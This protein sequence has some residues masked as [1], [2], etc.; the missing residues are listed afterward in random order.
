MIWLFYVYTDFLICFQTIID[1]VDKAPISFITWE[2]DPTTGKLLHFGFFYRKI[3]RRI[4]KILYS[5]H[6]NRQFCGDVIGQMMVCQNLDVFHPYGGVKRPS[7]FAEGKKTDIRHFRWLLALVVKKFFQNDYEESCSPFFKLIFSE[8]FLHRD[9]L[10][11]NFMFQY[12]HPVLY[13]NKQKFKFIHALKNFA[14]H[15]RGMFY[16]ENGGLQNIAYG[17]QMWWTRIAEDK[18]ETKETMLG[19]VYYYEETQAYENRPNTLLTYIRNLQ[20]HFMKGIK[21]KNERIRSQNEQNREENI[22]RKAVNDELQYKKRGH[23]YEF[24]HFLFRYLS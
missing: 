15:N 3:F 1:F 4:G 23:G 20:E 16:K 2:F 13:G 14:D 21:T 10:R 5:Y 8:V 17:F 18:E 22:R 9:V 24:F 7:D 12:F 19:A 6:K 11:H